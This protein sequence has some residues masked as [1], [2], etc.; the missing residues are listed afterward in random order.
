VVVETRLHRTLVG[1]LRR[2]RR[3]DGG[4]ST[5]MPGASEVEPTAVAALALRDPAAQA[6]LARRQAQSGAIDEDDGR[7]NGPTTAALASL[8]LGERSAAR[9]SLDY[10]IAGRGLPLPNAKDPDRR[11]GWGWT[12]DTR[13]L[14]EPTAR[15]LLAVNA[16]TPS[17]AAV[18]NEAVRLM[19]ERQCAD[20][21][22]NFGNAS[23]YDVDLKSYPQTTAVAL[24]GL[25]RAGGGLV[26]PALRYLE[27]AWRLE[28]GGLTLA[29]TVVAFR[30]HGEQ[31]SLAGPLA[32][33]E[34]LA[35]QRAFT[36]RPLAVAWAVLATGPD[37]LLEPLRSRA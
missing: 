18:R 31:A 12:T 2:A 5:A 16:L 35:T 10:A 15:V 22:W 3:L 19:R 4:F 33:L 30:L 20:G 29:Q 37:A 24:I 17:N 13:S 25:Q 1:T 26:R 32:A 11:T 14:V 27:R 34:G 28:P 21:G 36:S 6:W 9:R 8:A 23:V 7:V